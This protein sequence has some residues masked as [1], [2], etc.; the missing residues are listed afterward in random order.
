M[1]ANEAGSTAPGHA[2]I[3]PGD[4]TKEIPANPFGF[5]QEAD[6]AVLTDVKQT[7]W[8]TTAG[9]FNLSGLSLKLH[10]GVDECY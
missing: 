10:T 4:K 8:A 9:T 5:A 2:G 6:R 7:A 3:A 1:S